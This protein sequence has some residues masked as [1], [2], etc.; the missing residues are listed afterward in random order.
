M[1]LRGW[2]DVQEGELWKP[3]GQGPSCLAEGG[4]RACRWKQARRKPLRA[5]Q[6]LGNKTE[7]QR[8]KRRGRSE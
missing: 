3:C 4:G 7:R 6:S 8:K 2:E 5:D 1:V